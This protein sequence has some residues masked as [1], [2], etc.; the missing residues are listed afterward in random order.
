MKRWLAA[1]LFLAACSPQPSPLPPEPSTAAAAAIP[2]GRTPA[3]RREVFRAALELYDH[4]DVAASEP[5]FDRVVRVYPELADY[6]TRY[7]AKVAEARGDAAGALARWQELASLHP[8]SLWRGEAELA[9]GRARGLVGDWTSA[10]MLL[11]SAR[12]RL[13]EAKDQAEALALLAEAT[14]SLGDEDAARA[15]LVDL[16]SHYP[17]SPQ[18]A[19]AREEAWQR[20]ESVALRSARAAREEAGLLLGEGE[21]ERALT[22]VREAEHSFG[23]TAELPGLLWVE[24]TALAKLGRRDESLGVL[25]RIVAA[26]PRDPTAAQALYRMA[27]LAWNRNEDQAALA[28]FRRYTREYPR[29]EQAAEATYAVGRIEQEAHRYPAAARAY[30]R[31]AR[32]YP[33]SS[34]AT[35]ARFRIGWCWYRAGE[36]AAAARAFRESARTTSGMDRAAALY[37]KAR[38]DSNGDGYRDLIDEFPESYYAALAER[39]LGEV[40]GATLRARVPG[41][42]SSLAS[43]G[44]ACAGGD[45]D[46]LARFE[47]LKAMELRDFARRELAAF[48][49]AVSGCDTFLVIAWTEV[50]GYRESIGRAQKAGN[51][52]L[53]SA[54]L[55]YCYPL[56][57]WPLVEG[58]VA[59]RG[60]DPFLVAGLIRQ[61]SL[62]DARI[63]SA[64]NA[65]GL[66]QILPST[67]ARLAAEAGLSDF[68]EERLLEPETNVALGTTY[69]RDLL[70]RYQGNLP[71]ALAAYNAG[72]AAVDRWN[73]RYP[74]VEDDEFVESISFRETRGYV[75]RVLQNRRL[76]LALYAPADSRA[77]P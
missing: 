56:G 41:T 60:L 49:Q 52:G 29:G 72:E 70:A 47:E 54:L 57:Y 6:G 2:E 32:T 44:S 20:R 19:V 17:R 4:G 59:E 74:G 38:A 67:G 65:V 16:R 76:Y 68:H 15:A 12:P 43:S 27:S 35:E 33:R 31:L 50:D 46:R 23:S 1:I 62:F 26:Y 37:W 18:A 8:G 14:R 9:I 73:E 55:R 48:Q 5:L 13:H 10:A 64:A 40:E 71:R 25:M 36:R 39:R 61:E 63:R 53:A 66:M 3:E 75:K 45:S 34:L 30:E 21:A 11:R 69:L 7:L 77:T 42:A 51:C 22:L 58:K 24:A 28:L